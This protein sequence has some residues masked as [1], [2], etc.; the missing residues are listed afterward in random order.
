MILGAIGQVGVD[1]GVGYVVEYAGEAIRALSMEQRMTICNMTIEW[2]ARAGLIA[3]DETTFAYLEGRPHAPQGDDWERAVADWRSLASDPDATYDTHVVVDVDRARA[4]GDVGH[5]SGHGRP[6]HGHRARPERRSPTPTTGTRPSARS[7][8][9]G[10]RRGPADRGD[11]RST[12][13]SS[14]RARTRASRIS[15]LRRRSF[16]AG[17]S[18]RA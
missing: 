8:Y 17:R 14:A 15:A 3:P 5:E 9:M 7:T 4:A 1:G 18:T 2:G 10:L 6:G 16:A 11:P 13:S 12:A